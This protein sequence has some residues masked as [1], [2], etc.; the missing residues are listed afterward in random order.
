MAEDFD[1]EDVLQRAKEAGFRGFGGG[2]GWAAIAIN[3]VLLEGKEEM[4]GAFNAAFW[5]K[6]RAIGHVAVFHDG[7][8]WDS[9]ATPKSF[10]DFESWGML[11]E[12]DPDYREQAQ[13]LGIKW[14]AP[15]DENVA[16][17]EEAEE[18]PAY[19]VLVS[20]MSEEEIL[21][22]FPD[23]WDVIED[24]T[25]I[26]EKALEEHLAERKQPAVSISV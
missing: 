11:D 14:P 20:R 17:G 3:R 21:E 10:E 26:L 9:D 6:D 19:E 2:C 25:E 22:H 8:F 13:E 24:M 15:A 1:I 12:H 18:H 4:S 5:R 7:A 16:E 23:N